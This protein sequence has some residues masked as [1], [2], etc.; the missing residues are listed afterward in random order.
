LLVSLVDFGS[1][2]FD[3]L[4]HLRDLILRKPLGMSFK[5]DEL[6]S[7]YNSIHFA[8]Y[9]NDL[10]L[11]GTLVMK[12][13]DNHQIK[14]RQVAVFPFAQR[15]GV[16]Q[17]MVA[18]SETYAKENNFKEIVLSARVPAVPFYEK[19]G[20]FVTSGLYQEVGIDHYKMVKK[21]K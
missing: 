7:E 18:A 13:L 14:M 9:T 21:L 5:P 20:Y 3:E 12:P 11:L 6:S 8:A 10:E 1:P 2:S 19:L 16:G 15:K 17:L 4:V